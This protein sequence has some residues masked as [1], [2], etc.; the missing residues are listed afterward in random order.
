MCEYHESRPSPL[1][2]GAQKHPNVTAV[3][4]SFGTVR[5]ERTDLRGDKPIPPQGGDLIRY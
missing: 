3:L 2:G 5:L 4:Q 1:C